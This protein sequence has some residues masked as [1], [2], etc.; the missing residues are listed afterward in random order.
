MYVEEE[1]GALLPALVWEWCEDNCQPTPAH[2]SQ[3]WHTGNRQQQLQ[4]QQQWRGRPPLGATLDV[5]YE[6]DPATAATAAIGALPVASEAATAVEPGLGPGAPLSARGVPQVGGSDGSPQRKGEAWSGDH[7]HAQ[8]Q[9]QQQQEGPDQQLK[10]QPQQRVQQQQHQEPLLQQPLR[11]QSPL[12]SQSPRP[13]PQV[14]HSAAL[15]KRLAAIL[16]SVPV[17]A[18]LL[19]VSGA[20]DAVVAFQNDPSLR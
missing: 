11:S 3:A 7:P 16:G 20:N 5:I 10:Q 12:Q 9:Q 17:I 14:K 6:Y 19:D 4:Q 2:D 8:Q 15:D 1:G 18:T 13:E